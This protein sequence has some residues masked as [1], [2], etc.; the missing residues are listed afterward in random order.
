MGNLNLKINFEKWH[1]LELTCKLELRNSSLISETKLEQEEE[2]D[3]MT[4]EIFVKDTIS[5][6]VDL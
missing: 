6:P 1:S 5:I 3:L 2:V 4:L